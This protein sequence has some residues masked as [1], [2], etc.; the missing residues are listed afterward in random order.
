[1]TWQPIGT[2]PKDGTAVLLYANRFGWT[3]GYAIVCAAYHVHQW[4]IYGAAGGQAKPGKAHETQWLDEVQP[5]HW[6]PLPAVPSE[7]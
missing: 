5:T 7:P 4:R 2:A 3:A 6:M 1:M